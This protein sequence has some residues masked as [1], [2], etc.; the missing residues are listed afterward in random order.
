MNEVEFNLLDEPWIRVRT[1]N[2]QIHEVSLNDLFIHSHEYVD[3]A[4]EMEA[5]DIAVLRLCLAVMHTVF[6]R[7]DAEGNENHL[8]GSDMAL[9]RW[10][11]LWQMGRFPE[12]IIREYLTKCRERFWLFHPEKPFFQV[13][14]AKKGT[15]YTAAKLNGEISESSNKIK[16]FAM[17]SKEGK[18]QLTYAEA[19]RWLLFINGLR[20]ER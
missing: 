12:D 9:D 15:K 13:N 5:Q 4:G 6:Y 2:C 19:A 10:E 7:Y 18:E 14:E 3:F 8:D 20:K 11:D 16:M 17:R 1:E